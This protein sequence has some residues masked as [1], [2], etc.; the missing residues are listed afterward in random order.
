MLSIG[1]VTSLTGLSRLGLPVLALGAALAVLFSGTGG[2]LAAGSDEDQTIRVL[3]N[4]HSINYGR[5]ITFELELSAE[6]A[7]IMEIQALFKPDGPRVV[8]SYSYPDFQPGNNVSA[9]FQIPTSGNDFFPPG[10][11]LTVSYRII[12]S[13]GQEFTTDPVRIEYLDPKFQWD[14]RTEDRLTIV[15]HDRSK[16]D[17][18][19]LFAAANSRMPEIARVYGFESEGEFKAVLINSS[20]EADL[21]F[22][23]TTEAARSGHTF[24]GF[25]FDE[26]DQFVLWGVDPQSFV[27]EL[28]HLMF[29]EAVPSAI[30]SPPAWLN[31]GLSVYFESNDSRNAQTRLRGVNDEDDLMPIKNMNRVPGQRRDITFFYGKSGSFVGFLINEF[32]AD[33]MSALMGELNRGTRITQAISTTYGFELD[34]LDEVWTAR[35]FGLAEPALI[36]VPAADSPA[37]P[38]DS[39]PQAGTEGT[40]DSP[41]EPETQTRAE[42]TPTPFVRLLK[43][44]TPAGEVFAESRWRTFGNWPV[45]FSSVGAIAGLLFFTLRS[46]K[47]RG[48][49]RGDGKH[50]TTGA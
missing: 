42:I 21:A 27:H 50:R 18:D 3:R 36:P 24:I 5:D 48:K 39:A 12:D 23:L 46:L 13:A 44:E 17:I 43:P 37:T 35:Q 11:V 31:E 41:G 30:A 25:A 1:P 34:N 47:N 20:R 19:R 15:F 40:T 33:R 6:G 22:P 28:A 16:S 2:A 29:A 8:S 14:R 26:F 9:S 38:A 10:T 32:G 45:L 7:P 49:S 4:T